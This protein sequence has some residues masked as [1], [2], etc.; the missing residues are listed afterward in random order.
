MKDVSLIG[1]KQPDSQ[2]AFNQ[3][4]SLSQHGVQCVCKNA[5]KAE[6]VED[7]YGLKTY[8]KLSTADEQS[9]K[10]M[11]WRSGKKSNKDLKHDLRNASGPSANLSTVH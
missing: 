9:L 6:Q 10:F 4:F 1:I 3:N 11:S 2:I 7:K 5:D 8:L